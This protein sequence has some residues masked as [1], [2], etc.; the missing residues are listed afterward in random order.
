M[1]ESLFWRRQVGEVSNGMIIVVVF[2][3]MNKR[4][5]PN[6]VRSH[7]CLSLPSL[8]LTDISHRQGESAESKPELETFLEWY[9]FDC[10]SFPEPIAFH[11]VLTEYDTMNYLDPVPF[12]EVLVNDGDGWV[13]KITFGLH[14]T[15]CSLCHYILCS[16]GVPLQTNILVSDTAQPHLLSQCPLVEMASTFSPS[17]SQLIMENTPTSPWLSI[18]TALSAGLMG[19]MPVVVLV[20]QPRPPAAHWLTCRKVVCVQFVAIVGWCSNLVTD[21]WQAV[22]HLAAYHTHPAN[23][24]WSFS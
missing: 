7:I 11:T 5:E 2:F 14:A 16:F 17:T 6:A 8:Y 9:T 15:K 21:L 18:S 3:V 13:H 19:T 22:S 24:S 1:R 12:D 4:N 23:E 10:D 20:M